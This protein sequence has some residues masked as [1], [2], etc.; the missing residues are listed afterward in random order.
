LS[1]WERE[2]V[3]RVNIVLICMDL[4]HLLSEF[5]TETTQTDLTLY[6]G[7]KILIVVDEAEDADEDEDEDEAVVVGEGDVD[8]EEAEAVVVVV[9]TVEE[10]VVVAIVTVHTS[11]D[12][13][14]R[15]PS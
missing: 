2:R 5:L 3:Q 1:F 14:N 12:G 6:S 13:E 15:I 10:G 9:V 7:L 11:K 8:E 4:I